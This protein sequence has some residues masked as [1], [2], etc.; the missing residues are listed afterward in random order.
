MWAWWLPCPWWSSPPGESP[1]LPSNPPPPSPPLPLPLLLLLQ[2]TCCNL[3]RSTAIHCTHG[4]RRYCVLYKSNSNPLP[5]P[6]A[7]PNQLSDCIHHR[8]LTRSAI[9]RFILRP[10]VENSPKTG[11]TVVESAVEQTNSGKK[12]CLFSVDRAGG[13]LGN[14]RSQLNV[15]LCPGLL[16]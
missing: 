14:H 3:L 8:P 15:P 10:I 16:F 12:C 13:Q 6:L 7:I 4:G 1:Q 2:V 9:T 11:D 5:P